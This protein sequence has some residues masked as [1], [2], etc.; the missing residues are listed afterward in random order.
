M[1]HQQAREEYARALRSGLREQKEL[2]AAG[3]NPHP[4][5]LD[6]ILPVGS[7]DS[8]QEF[9]PVE[10]P[11]SQIVGT[12]S[13][14]RI[15]AFSAS[16]WPLLPADSEFAS[17]W[18][19]LCADHLGDVGIR[20][21]I[22]CYEYLGAFYV[23]EG[24]KRLSVLKH[25]DAAKIFAVVRRILPQESDS[26]RVRAYYEFLDFYADTGIYSVQ[27]RKPGE[28][29]KLLAFLGKAPGEPW[30]QKEKQTFST[31]LHN[32]REAF[33]AMGGKKIPIRPE[34]ALLLWLQVHP[35]GDLGKLPP[36]DL[37]KN[38]AILWPDLLAAANDQG[39]SV[40]TTPDTA[41]KGGLLGR[42]INLTPDHL[43]VAFVHQR[44][45]ETSTW[46]K[47]HDEGRQ[48]LDRVLSGYV[49]TRSYYN[50]DTPEQAEKAL[51]QAVADGAQVVFTTT[52]QLSRVTL[53]VALKYPKIRFLN[54]SVDLPYSSIRTYYSRVYEGK[55]VTGAIAG[56]MAANDRIGYIGSSPIFGVP[57]SINAFA[58]GAL[59]TNP[60]ATIE[61]RW[62]CLAGNPVQELID[63]G[64]R[65]ISNRDV[66]TDDQKYLD[67][68][69]YGTYLVDQEG[70]LVSLG[71]PV[72]VWGKFY[73]NTVGSILAGTWSDAKGQAVNYWWGMDSGVIDVKLSDALPPGVR[74]MA[75]M[76]RKGIQYGLIDPF[77]RIIT[78]QDGTLK[79]DGSHIFTPDELLHMDWLC[80]SIHGFIPEFDQVEPFA[81]SIVR[82]LGIYRD[83]IP[84][85]KEEQP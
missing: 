31:C 19:S 69:D 7:Y 26:P 27:F 20:E 53:K 82:A 63:S 39:V 11:V 58:L 66:P 81:Q 36:A 83:R 75:Q 64:V 79:N 3:K 76:L 84:P 38:L 56:A 52:P 44:S 50:A 2:L 80:D 85:Q 73:E 70:S 22:L 48:Y 28:Y 65:V 74:S 1:Y 10:I 46:T 23:Q 45:P 42:L 41:V 57:A 40:R 54:C 12:K 24:N 9:G 59:M 55:F 6:E 5:V 71:S 60:R 25:F 15:H 8:Y 61:L 67:L 32:F 62:S 17:K 49:S 21:P 18:V 33:F 34:D 51:E 29:A 78:A 43:N 35:Y 72:W 30:S 14:G 4:S 16:F 13:A 37:K 47:A 77:Q 68:C